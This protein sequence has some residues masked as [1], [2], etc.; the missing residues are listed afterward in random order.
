MIPP[1][2]LS[3]FSRSIWLII[4]MFVAFAIF[5]AIYVHSEKQI[6]RANE[7]R[8]QSLALADELRQSSDDLTRMVRSYVF[9]GKARGC[10]VCFVVI[11][12]GLRTSV[13]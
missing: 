12:E 10:K 4:G 2:N 1:N 8:F 13:R 9:T 7:L 6:E 3:R 5:F 11:D